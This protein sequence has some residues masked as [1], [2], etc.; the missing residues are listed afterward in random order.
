MTHV[1]S[2]CQAIVGDLA[3]AVLSTA[4]SHFLLLDLSLGVEYAR[5]RSQSPHDA[6]TLRQRCGNERGDAYAASITV[7]LWSL[8]PRPVQC[9]PVARGRARA[10][11]AYR[12][13]PP[14]LTGHARWA[15][16]PQ[17]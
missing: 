9:L 8:P 16:S 12:L 13:R 1:F 5:L 10:A 4:A 11:S 6:V 3:E 17:R 7:D 14:A 15:V 2:P